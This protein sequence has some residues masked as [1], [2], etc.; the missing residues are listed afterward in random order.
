MDSNI[1]ALICI[2]IIGATLLTFIFVLPKRKLVEEKGI[3]PLYEERCSANWKFGGGALIAGG[4]IPIA[5]I[6][7]YENFFVVSMLCPTKINYSEIISADFK[8][9]WFS[10]S[11]TL[12]FDKGNSLVIRPQNVKKIQSI[13]A[14]KNPKVFEGSS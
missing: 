1:F 6:S 4:N 9:N 5:R 2:A 11:V 8:S 10:K 12:Y 14:A 13:V 3:T 7:F